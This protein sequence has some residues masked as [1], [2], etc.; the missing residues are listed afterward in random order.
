M[1]A[2]TPLEVVGPLEQRVLEILCGKFNKGPWP[3]SDQ[4]FGEA[5]RLIR[6]ESGQRLSLSPSEA[7]AWTE[8][9]LINAFAG[10]SRKHD[11]RR[12]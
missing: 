7:L 12:P 8:D 5:S 2:A 1:S 3:P 10:L 9:D 6:A 11:E 4:A